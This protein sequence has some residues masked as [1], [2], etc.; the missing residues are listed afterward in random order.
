M[1]GSTYRV[2]LLA[3]AVAACTGLIVAGS[4][5]ADPSALAV[6]Y[7]IDVAHSGVQTDSALSP[8]FS[9]RWLTTLPAQV[10]YP[11]IAEGKV[12]VTA[13]STTDN[14][15]RTPRLYALDQTSGQV[16]WSQ[17][18]PL[19]WSRANAAYDA[20]R[21][22]VSG[23]NP[24]L[25]K[26]GLSDAGVM[27]AY[28][29]DTGNLLWRTELPSQYI[30]TSAPTAAHGV[31]YVG[32]AGLGG[33]LYAVSEADG[34][35]LAMQ[36]VQNGDQSSPALSGDAV[37]VSYACNQAYGFAQTT[38]APLWH[39]DGPCEGGGG[40]TAVYANGRVY[41]R[42]FFGSLVLDATNGALLR[43]YEPE[44]AD[45]NA[46]AV[47]STSLFVTFPGWSINAESL[48][49]NPLWTFTG[50]GQLNTAP[51]ILNTGSNR[52]VIV[53]SG[54]GRLYAL[55]ADTGREVW[56]TDV[57]A[58]ITG[59]NEWTGAEPLAGLAAGQGLLIVPAGKTLSAYA[60]DQTPPV[61]SLPATVT[62]RGTSQS[63][64]VVTFTVSATD[65]DDTATA[66]CSPPSGSVFPVGVTTVTCTATD[67]AGNT[68]IDS[69]LVV[70]SAPNVDCNLAHYPVTKGS[71][72]LKDANLS[73]CYLPNASLAGANASGA[74]FSGAY[75][76]GANLSSVNFSQANLR[77]AVLTGANVSGVKWLQTTCPDGTTS[78]DHGA[79]CVGHLT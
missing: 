52:F 63:G 49:G 39:F 5:A 40:R 74:S 37:F 34:R 75:L 21:I 72:N 71:R 27:L 28:S 61:L 66:T 67:S 78:N 73:G 64:G 7:Q 20:G 16:L 70:V 47:D 2:K 22:F 13:G 19:L 1:R 54:L 65:P 26:P 15:T 59:T 58:P 25:G 53:G 12:F 43:N 42:D 69:F 51:L 17:T 68:A 62:A 14:A 6:A 4:A 60:S 33:T 32:G 48:D 9:R 8:P 46:P 44:R 29:A 3:F 76:A 50:D 38:L 23:V 31:V 77:G 30:F 18:L 36:S 35:V 41:T 55:Q 10:S 57:G 24:D 11:L 56:S 79:T 45:I